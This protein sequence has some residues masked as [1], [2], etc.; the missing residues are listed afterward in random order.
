MVRDDVIKTVHNLVL[1]ESQNG[2]GWKGS[3]QGT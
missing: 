3:Q 1:M 2:V